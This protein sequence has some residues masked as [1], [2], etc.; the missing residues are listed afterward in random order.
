MAQAPGADNSHY[1]RQNTFLIPFQADNPDRRIQ[2]VH[3]LRTRA[4]GPMVYIQMHIDLDPHQTLLQAHEIVEGAEERVLAA[5]P[6]ADVL[7]HPDPE[8]HAEPHGQFGEE[9]R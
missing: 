3:E 2:N 5:F 6:A 7:I 4:S 9:V 1:T 8:G